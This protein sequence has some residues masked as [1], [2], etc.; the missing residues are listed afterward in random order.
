MTTLLV[1]FFRLVLLALFALCFIVLFERGP[2]GFVS[3]FLPE[4]QAAIDFVTGKG[5]NRSGPK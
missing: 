1:L 4:S 2:S 3:G 5:D